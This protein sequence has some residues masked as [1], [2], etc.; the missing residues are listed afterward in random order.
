[1]HR[2]TRFIAFGGPEN[3]R[4]VADHAIVLGLS[5]V[6]HND[7][8]EGSFRCPMVPGTSLERMVKID[9]F[10]WIQDIIFSRHEET[11]QPEKDTRGPMPN[12]W[13][14]AK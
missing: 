14:R 13:S 6:C 2:F 5:G 10:S 7:T 8:S 1:M 11:P 12:L 9:H 3:D 4:L